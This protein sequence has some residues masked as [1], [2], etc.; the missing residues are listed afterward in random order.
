MLE[1]VRKVLSGDGEDLAAEELLDAL[2]LAARLPPAAA[3]A[4]AQVAAA[5][6]TSSALGPPDADTAAGHP[7]DASADPDDPRQGT[8]PDDP[9]AGSGPLPAPHVDLHAAPAA[10]DHRPARSDRPAM[11]VRAPGMRA[12]G[13]GELRLGRA[14]RPLKHRR[15][16]ALRTELDIAATVSAMAETGLPEAV[17]R[18]ARTRW[19]DLAILVD[20]GISMLLWQRLAGEIRALAERSG[21][22]RHVRVH[23]L[24]SRAADGPLL[25]RRPYGAEAATL[26]MSTVLDPSGH[27]LLLVVSDGVGPAWR[28]GR[29]HAALHRSAA[30]GPT[31]LVNVLPTRLWAGSGI[32]AEPWRV[33]TRR[34]GAANR[35]WDV[36]DPVLPPELATFD[37]VPVPVLAVQPE[38]LGAWARLIGSPGGSAVL[39]LLAAP[40]GVSAAAAG[41]STGR[42]HGASAAEQEVLRFRE[43]ASTDAYRLAA[44]L[45]AV[46]PLPVPVMRLVQHAVSPAADTSH[47]AE[48]FLGGLMHSADDG[49]SL[50]HQRT[51]D[52]AEETR[53]I[54]LGTVA[55]SELV[56]T[57]RAVTTQLTE[58][59]GSPACFPAWLPHPQGTERVPAGN[60]RPFGW[61]DATVMRRLGVSLPGP[62]ETTRPAPGGE[63]L[64]EVPPGFELNEDDTGWQR[65]TVAD[66]RFDASG[67]MPYEV[68]AEHLGGWSRAGLFMGHDGEG[69]ILIV[70]R[71][72]V[73][74][75]AGLVATEVAALK[76]MD[77]M[78]A[79]RLL[80]W[81][82]GCPRPWLA[83]ECALDGPTET[84]PDLR[85]FAERH[86]LLHEAGLLTVAR[87]FAA[88]IARA[89]RKRLVHGSLTPGSVLIAG[90]EVRIAGWMTA[91]VDGTV[92][93]HRL[94]HR[95]NLRY[96]APELLDAGTE[97]TRASDV[98]A[99]GR[100]LV[101]AVTGDSAGVALGPGDVPELP[102]DPDV[103]D[104][105]RACLAPDPD[106]RPAADQ[107]RDVFDATAREQR[108]AP[109]HRLRVTL[110]LDSSGLPVHLDLEG[111]GRGGE[112]PHVL[113]EART[114]GR[115]RE[116]QRRVLRQLMRQNP[117]GMKLVLA[118]LSGNTAALLP[119]NV[120]PGKYVGLGAAPARALDLANRLNRELSRREDLLHRADCPDMAAYESGTVG[121]N[122]RTPL[123]RLIVVMDEVTRLLPLA[124][125]L[126]TALTRTAQSGERLGMHLVLFTGTP[127]RTWL[128]GPFWDLFSTRVRLLGS[129]DV[130]EPVRGAGAE[131]DGSLHVGDRRFVW[132]QANRGGEHDGA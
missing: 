60:R 63:P 37:G 5:A 22:F 40:Q 70:R 10:A 89:H 112:G 1:H 21:A 109:P 61:V 123:P 111:E 129:E 44:H 65:L 97:P 33:T 42:G 26:P 105:L 47:L 43:A 45:A 110:G 66:P 46:A 113:C 59:A 127:G 132:F 24:D 94:L 72:Q 91:T 99:F 118:D 15:P 90:R 55:P 98:Y 128:E 80:A 58:L 49:E 88:G 27:T 75:A 29:M 115:R 56:R 6:G 92:S 68:F 131:E 79:P 73:P 101:E 69:R 122:R 96:R 11:P 7:A 78:Y 54:L 51:F 125:E 19:L 52:F 3:T 36:A 35:S 114:T 64:R 108:H 93:P 120:L 95:H 117:E 57:T 107:L 86:G 71:P 34:R 31:A 18:P 20:D 116:L 100:I 39:P 106:R 16:D 12:L 32:R 126:R 124:P 30:T 102:L 87:Q 8:A 121:M 50:P 23:G 2:W 13:A 9:S 48:V 103:A 67:S 74:H 104:T 82:T 76:R 62:P 81:D 28:D 25:S 84:A 130:A 17:L 41:L 83:M 119:S 77:G 85:A 14:L 4:L 53:R 38:S